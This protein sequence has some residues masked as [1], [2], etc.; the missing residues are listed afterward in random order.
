MNEKHMPAEVYD[1]NHPFV[2]N[3]IAILILGF[4]ALLIYF[5]SRVSKRRE[6]EFWRKRDEWNDWTNNSERPTYHK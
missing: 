3:L 2:L 6:E 1:L 4:L 5:N